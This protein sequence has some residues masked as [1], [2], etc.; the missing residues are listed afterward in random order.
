MSG[1]EGEMVV[2]HSSKVKH[3]G[4]GLLFSEILGGGGGSR[5]MRD[6]SHET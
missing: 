2:C 3:S 1:E 5:E 6:H 4:G